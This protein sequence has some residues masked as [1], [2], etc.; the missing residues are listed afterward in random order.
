MVESASLMRS[1]LRE[2]G[3]FS[4]KKRMLRRD[5][6]ALYNCLRERCQWSVTKK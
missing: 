4:L 1:G 6:I 2:L 3:V 5:L